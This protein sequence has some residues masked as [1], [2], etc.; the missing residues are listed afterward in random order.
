MESVLAGDAAV[1]YSIAFI[2]TARSRAVV[3]L[4]MPAAYALPSSTPR[5]TS[6]LRAPRSCAVALAAGAPTTAMRVFVAR[7]L[8]RVIMCSSRSCRVTFVPTHW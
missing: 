8:E 6:V 3:M 4:F 7:L 5:R 1:P 2:N